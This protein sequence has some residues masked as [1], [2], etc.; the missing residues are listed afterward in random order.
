MRFIERHDVVRASF[1]LLL[2][3]LLV[4]IGGCSA[5]PAGGDIGDGPPKAGGTGGTGGMGGA[6]STAAAGGMG[7]GGAGG[8]T[9]GS[10]GAPEP[11]TLLAVLDDSTPYY[12]NY[13]QGWPQNDVLTVVD[14]AKPDVPLL[15]L[16]KFTVGAGTGLWVGADI[17]SW[18][19][20]ATS[21]SKKRLGVID[22]YA[23]RLFDENLQPLANVELPNEDGLAVWPTDDAIFALINEDPTWGD[24]GTILKFDSNGTYLQTT[25]KSHGIDLVVDED[26]QVVWTVGLYLT[27]ATTDLLDEQEL[28]QFGFAA[29]SLDLDANGGIWAVER[30]DSYNVSADQLVHFDMNGDIIIGDTLA[31]PD[32]PMSVRVDRNS[33]LVWVAMTDTGA[34]GGVAY[35]DVDGQLK[36]V[37]G[38]TGT[39]YAVEPDPLDGSRVWAASPT[40]EVVHVDTNGTVIQSLGGF[41]P[42]RK[43]LA[44]MQ[45]GF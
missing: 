30:F 10:G 6:D 26:N 19:T 11:A 7:P 5:V 8:A 20:V 18:R 23:L 14:P 25:F 40:G 31:L 24:S 38:L 44:V 9:G 13:P 43:W 21:K 16:G 17:G 27:R 29:V 36:M 32:S 2:V 1:V 22:R 33:G 39:W 42:S 28:H 41:S 15:K 4:A 35:R 3:P 37:P 45:Q 12:E 34:G